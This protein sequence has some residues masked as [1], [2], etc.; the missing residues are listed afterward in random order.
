MTCNNNVVW[1][2]RDAVE[3]EIVVD[4]VYLLTT[5]LEQYDMCIC[6]SLESNVIAGVLL[7]DEALQ[8]HSGVRH[9]GTTHGVK[10][11]NQER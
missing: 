11:S 10:V 6:Y 8:V 9:T 1:T 4:S 2:Y 5:A 7:F 3:C